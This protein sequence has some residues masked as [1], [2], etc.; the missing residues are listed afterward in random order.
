MRIAPG[1]QAVGDTH[2]ADVGRPGIERQVDVAE[3][4]PE[5]TGTGHRDQ[6]PTI[7]RQAAVVGGMGMT[8]DHQ[9]DCGIQLRDDVGD[10]R[11]GELSIAAVDVL[12]RSAL[13]SAFVNQHHDRL[14]A[15]AANLCNPL[16]D[17]LRLIDEFQSS[18]CAGG[19]DRR[20]CLQGQPD[21][22]DPHAIEGLHAV[23]GQQGL[24]GLDAAHIG[25]QPLKARAF[26]RNRRSHQSPL[27]PRAGPARRRRPAAAAL[28]SEQL[29]PALVEFMVA[30]RRELQTDPVQCLD[31]RLVV[32]E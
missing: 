28:Q 17:R 2:G 24:A 15:L 19:H 13:G 22:G 20:R 6:P 8:A 10:R 23:G 11:S 21:E 5:S 12:N 29:G 14:D 4:T 25:R 1:H 7:Q 32:K 27:T 18:D 9:V 16:I 31:R 3:H 30:D 26:K